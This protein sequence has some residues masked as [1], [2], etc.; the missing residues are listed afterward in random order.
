MA[1]DASSSASSL[2]SSVISRLPRIETGSYMV[3]SP[4][5]PTASGSTTS[6][7]ASKNALLGAVR[8]AEGNL[9]RRAGAWTSA[10]VMHRWHGWLQQGIVSAAVAARTWLCAAPWASPSTRWQER[11]P[12]RGRD[13]H[14][15][16]SRRPGMSTSNRHKRSGKDPTAEAMQVAAALPPRACRPLHPPARRA[17]G[18]V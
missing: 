2:S 6:S 7:R 16:P 18:A 14:A 17:P 3:C 10:E 8:P 5:L 13:G 9:P 4:C 1:M 11:A 12:P 15:L